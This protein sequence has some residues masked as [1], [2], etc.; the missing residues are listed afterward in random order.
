MCLIFVAI[1]QHPDFPVIIAANRDEF[2]DRPTASAHFWP[3]APGVLAGRDERAR[4]TWLGVTRQGR[5]AAVTN[6]REPEPRTHSSSRGQIVSDFL[7]GPHA[8]DT[9]STRLAKAAGDFAGFNCLYGSLAT[10]GELFYF[11]NRNREGRRLDPGIHGL[12]NALLDSDW[13]KIR[14]GKAA[15]ASLVQ[16]PYYAEEWL[17]MLMDRQPAPELELPDTGIGLEK[18]RLL[19]PRFIRSDNYGTRSSTLVTVSRQRQITLTE[20]THTPCGHRQSRHFAF[21]IEA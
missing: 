17:A 14:T 3:D 6:Y 9:Y 7:Q 19:S 11:S 2:Y 4:G 21:G 1:N 15:I 16:R 5:F 20:Y 13:P 10:P 18:E 8:P 12:S